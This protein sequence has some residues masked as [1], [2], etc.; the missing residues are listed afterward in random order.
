MHQA[1][2]K[3]L[4]A[5]IPKSQITDYKLQISEG[6]V[7]V[8]IEKIKPNRYQ[9]RNKFKEENLTELA[10]SIKEK[11]LLQ[12]LVISPSAI[13]GEY[14]L[15]AGERRLRAAKLA[16]LN[17]VKVIIRPEVTEQERLQIS[18][19]ENLQREDLNP[20]EEAQAYQKLIKEFGLTQEEL[21]QRLGKSR[22]AI[23][24]TLRLLN[25]PQE[26]KETIASGTISSGHARNLVGL[27]V[28]EIQKLVQRIIQERLSVRETEKIVERFKVESL[29]LRKKKKI[30]PELVSLSEELQHLL[31]T[32]IKIKGNTK[33]GRIEI[34]YYSLSDLERL[35]G[36]IK[37]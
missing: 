10:N 4:E 24:N 16:G 19:I 8:P 35:I 21:A 29:K 14:E 11:G 36:L 18:L 6:I 5:L 2:G 31:G 12:P 32:K 27:P 33:K 13:P 15:L 26:I 22:A 17:E 37:R 20:I 7:K 30:L 23:A 34:Y 9:P 25:L 1:L 3:G 28:E